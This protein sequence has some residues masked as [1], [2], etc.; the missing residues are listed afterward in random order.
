[1]NAYGLLEAAGNAE[2]LARKEQ[3]CP[4]TSAEDEDEI[5]ARVF[6]GAK[7]ILH[8]PQ[9]GYYRGTYAGHAAEGN[10]RQQGSSGGI[11]T[12]LLEAL[13]SQN[14]VDAVIHVG[15]GTTPGRTFEYVVSRS[16]E[17]LRRNAK[18]RYYPV[19]FN[20]ALEAVSSIPNLRFAF[21]GVPCH[22]KAVRLLCAGDSGLQHRARFLIGIFCGHQ[23]S[24]AFA[25]SLGWQLGFPPGSL[26]DIDFRTKDHS[27]PANRYA[28]T[29]SD[30]RGREAQRTSARLHGADW[31]TGMFKPKACDWCD[32]VAAE[33][34]D[35]VTG[36]AWLPGYVRDSRG[37]NIVITR[38]PR[39]QELLLWGLHSGALRLDPIA[40]QQVVQSQAAS[41]RHRREGLAVRIR[42]ASREG[43]WHPTKRVSPAD[44]ALA[45]RRTEIYRLRSK[46]SEKSH[47]AF[48]EARRKGNFFRF[49]MAM[50]PL[51]SRYAALSG[52]VVALRKLWA[53]RLRMMVS[54]LA[55][56][57]SWPK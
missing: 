44:F 26:A 6:K 35:I 22:I 40:P 43:R 15:R 14:E 33:T 2:A 24:A 39:L 34:A 45:R 12:W 41:Y 28:V 3:A 31:G 1:M 7:G 46:I 53:S 56:G 37:T 11:T 38:D 21:V 57:L 49:I 30:S 55:R 17:E 16:T 19:S 10:Y 36:D 42:E 52:G 54:H 20:N 9:I 27:Q 18:S 23:K 32:D 50:L 47:I 48:L 29:A 25:E 5:A 8:H 13:F 4:F 51:E